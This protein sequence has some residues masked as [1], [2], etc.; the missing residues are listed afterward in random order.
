[1]ILDVG[2]DE[3]GIGMKLIE[4]LV[5][6]GEEELGVEMEER[7]VFGDQRRIGLDDADQLDILIF[8][9]RAEETAGVV[10]H[11][12]DDDDADRC[13][14][15]YRMKRTEAG[16][17]ESEKQGGKPEFEEHGETFLFTTDYGDRTFLTETLPQASGAVYR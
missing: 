14:G 12:A 10:V 6:I 4:G 1:M 17:Q 5:E 2:V 16:K 3:D 7:G 11:E 13:A 8:G 9:K 15:S